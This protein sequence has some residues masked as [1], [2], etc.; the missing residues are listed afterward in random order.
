VTNNGTI[1]TPDGQTIL[2]AGLQVGFNAHPSGDPSLRGLDTYVGSVTDPSGT[3]TQSSGTVTNNGLIDAPRA[4]V[5]M[6]G[7]A[8]NQL[9]VI[10]SSTSVS[11]NGRIDLLANYNAI[12]NASFDPTVANS[13][14]FFPQ[15]SGTVTLGADSVTQILPEWSSTDRVVGTQ[16]ALPSQVNLQ[17]QAVH[18]ASGSILWAPNATVNVNAGVWAPGGLFIYSS[19]QIYLDSGATIDVAGSTD[20]SAPMSENLLTLQLRGPELA[21][22]PL[23]RTSVL[24]GAM[25]TIDVRQAGV[26]NGLDWIGTPLGDATGYVG[27]IQRTVGELTIGGGTV[28]LLSGSSVVMQRGS[29]VDVSGGWISYQGGMVQTTRVVSGADILDISQATPDRIYQGIYT[30]VFTVAH[31]SYGITENFTSPLAPMGIHYEAGYNYGGNGGSIVIQTPAAVLDGTLLGNTVAGPRQRTVIP[32]PSSLTLTFQAQG[33]TDP[34]APFSPS[35]PNITFQTFS[36][37]NPAGPFT[38]DANGV[39]LDLAFERKSQVILDPQLVSADG[40][41]SLTIN[42]GDGAILVPPNVSL[43]AP[44]NGSFTFAAANINIQGNLVAPGGK[45]SLTS[46]NQDPFIPPDPSSSAPAAAA[47]RGLTTIGTGASLSTAGLIVDDRHTLEAPNTLPL[48]INGGTVSINAFSAEL[49]LGSVIDVS[50]G[51]AISPTGKAT[52]GNGGSITILAGNDPHI[53][54]TLGGHLTLGATL[55]GFSGATGGSLTIQAPLIQVGTDMPSS[56]ILWLPPAFFS[57]GGF[58]N[59]ALIGL[60][61]GTVPPNADPPPPG[62]NPP[63]INIA[64]NTVLAPVAEN[65]IVEPT[66]PQ[67]QGGVDAILVPML[68]PVGLRKPVNLSFT[69]RSV[70]DFGRLLLRGDI[71]EGANSVIQTD[72]L[73]SVA[74]TGSTVTI[75]GKISAPGGSIQI[76][77]DSSFPTDLAPLAALATVYLGPQSSLSAAGTTLLLPDHYGRRVGSVL[78]GGTISV[79]GNIVAQAGSVLDV[80]GASGILDLAPANVGQNATLSPPLVPATS[81]L[82]S[83]LFSLQTVATRVDSNGGNIVLK[84]GQELFSDATL[85]GLRRSAAAFPF[86]RAALT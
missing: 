13:A 49:N 72:P 15:S 27:L 19:G 65:W 83:P 31:P 85:L 79:S 9:G 29:T 46:Y 25:I 7:M 23:Q 37:L 58:T 84:G 45:I 54:N 70:P 69:S 3:L 43:N 18:F 11:L 8:V 1:S 32:T 39:P 35:P 81:G 55:K 6:V 57:Q 42:N 34:F 53:P 82:L 50:G 12:S 5:T 47:N 38:V 26:Y 66:A 36:N 77:G 71:L 4:N 30:G 59:F 41:G 40:F 86:P 2:A 73:G 68:E 60:G 20:I 78:P 67:T 80:S 17:G 61:V 62:V 22:S 75:L 28:N 44:P 76:A 74:I 48:V 21:D 51:V 56:G 24:R 16:L 33:P 10:N 64:P 14:P 63:A 52:Y